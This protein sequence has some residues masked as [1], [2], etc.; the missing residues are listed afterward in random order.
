VVPARLASLSE[1]NDV[2]EN[3]TEGITNIR[4][5]DIDATMEMEREG[6]ILNE[7]S[8]YKVET[9]HDDS[10]LTPEGEYWQPRVTAVEETPLAPMP[11]RKKYNL[12]RQFSRY[13]KDRMRKVPLAA[14][15][16]SI[17]LSK[18]QKRWII[19]SANC[20][21]D[22]M[23]Q[24]LEQNPELADH[25][26]FVNGFTAFLWAAKHGHKKVLQLLAN[27]FPIDVSR[28]SV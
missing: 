19:A 27:N 2:G 7:E 4:D 11:R 21:Y 6:N 9:E 12:Q 16:E 5:Q 13:E 14:P 18:T 17:R 1:S 8:L 28:V 3:R 15:I 25:V 24:L 22:E 20:D 10:S 23:V 26:N